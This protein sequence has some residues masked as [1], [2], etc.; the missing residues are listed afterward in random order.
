MNWEKH[1]IRQGDSLGLIA[2]K[3]QTSVREIKN[4]NNMNSS[5]IRAGKTLL[6][7]IPKQYTQTTLAQ[8]KTKTR[9]T[10]THTHKVKANESLSVIAQN[11]NT[12]VQKISQINKINSKDLIKKGSNITNTCSKK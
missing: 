3:Y 1:K 11:H 6:I 4:L 7:P 2:Q 8:E 5:R 9:Q 10:K 12:T